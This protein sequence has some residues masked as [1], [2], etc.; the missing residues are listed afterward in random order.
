MTAPFTLPGYDAWRTTHPDDRPTRRPRFSPES[1]VTPL[2]I[3]SGGIQIDAEGRYEA[4]TGALVSVRIDGRD[5]SPTDVEAAMRLLGA[6]YVGWDDDL[7]PDKLADLVEEAA[8]DAEADW[9]DDM[10][11]WRKDE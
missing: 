9:A 1:V 2:L 5:I 3:E 11:D 10:R 4:A 6:G 8:R 7:H